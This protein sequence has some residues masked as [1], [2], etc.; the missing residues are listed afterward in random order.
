VQANTLADGKGKTA[1]QLLD[2]A[3]TDVYGA[4]ITSQ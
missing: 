1:Q 4:T 3:T 2:A